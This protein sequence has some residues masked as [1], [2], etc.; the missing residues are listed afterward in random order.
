[1][2]TTLIKVHIIN[3]KRFFFREET[4]GHGKE[5]EFSS[6]RTWYIH[7]FNKIPFLPTSSAILLEKL[8]SLY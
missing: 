6:Y 7:M 1:M 8:C 4:R 3:K 2:P 5:E